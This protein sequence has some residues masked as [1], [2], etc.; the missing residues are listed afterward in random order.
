[1]TTLAARVVRV[2]ALDPALVDPMYRLYAAHYDACDPVRFRS[3]L[4]GK[5]HV[6]LLEDDGR[7]CGF[8]TAVDH[9]FEWKGTRLR[10]LFS[11]DTIID[12]SAWG[13]QALSR[14]FAR[15]A[16]ALHAREPAVPLYWLLI[17][18]GHRTYRYLSVFARRFFPH[19]SGDDEDLLPLAGAIAAARFGADFDPARGVVAFP[20]S[21]GQLKPELADVPSRLSRRPEVAFF[22]QRNPGYRS[23]DELVCLTRLDPDNLRALVRA[24]FLAGMADGLD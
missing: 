23:G 22:L 5:D 9:P 20:R 7:L 3:D 1:V 4:A 12:R 21:L 13:Q 15:L 6:I 10:V 14:A 17:S 8:S 16:G 11:G 2:P 19:P 18:K 24:A